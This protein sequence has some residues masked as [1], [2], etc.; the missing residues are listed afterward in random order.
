[1]LR[2]LKALCIGLLLSGCGGGDGEE[3][4]SV[5]PTQRPDFIVMDGF[6]V[7]KPNDKTHIDLSKFIRGV[8]TQIVSAYVEG[9]NENC[10]VPE[11]NG[12]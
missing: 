2:K 10:G 6:S 9:I 12:I 7:V 11:I 8:D 5:T 4:P 3:I 1:M